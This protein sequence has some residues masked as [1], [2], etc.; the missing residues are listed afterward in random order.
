MKNV[1][2]RAQSIEKILQAA[3]E[4]LRE[5]G[6]AG[7]RTADVAIR[8][9][10]SH[11]SLFRY[12]PTRIDLL[13]AALE[14]SYELRIVQVHQW[15]EFF[16][17]HIHDRRIMMEGLMA[18]TES[19]SRW[20]WELYAATHYDSELRANVSDLYAQHRREVSAISQE[21]C[22]R[23]GV[24]PPEDSDMTIGMF[25]WCFQALTMNELANATN[26]DERK[27]IID[28]SIR[29]VNALYPPVPAN[30]LQ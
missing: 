3:L 21:F 4:L 27:N 14:R 1:D 11:G 20:E 9:G 28:F 24:I 15:N 23:T 19:T 16:A 6:Y 13:R 17:N 18:A 12:F 8:A 2:R 10:I 30:D 5:K 29:V 22:A 26:P 25:S 7:F